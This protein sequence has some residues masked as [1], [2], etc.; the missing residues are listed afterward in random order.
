MRLFSRQRH[1]TLVIGVIDILDDTDV[2]YS[3]RGD[4]YD[5][6]R[7]LLRRVTEIDKQWEVCIQCDVN[8]NSRLSLYCTF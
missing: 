6:W 8:E 4:I 1:F 3:Y 7:R 2:V 5:L